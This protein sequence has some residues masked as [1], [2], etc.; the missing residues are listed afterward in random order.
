MDCT[1]DSTTTTLLTIRKP[2]PTKALA[3][4]S[5]GTSSRAILRRKEIASGGG[6]SKLPVWRKKA[7][8]RLTHAQS[9]QEYLQRPWQCQ[10]PLRQ[11]SPHASAGAE[12]CGLRREDA[13][14]TPF[15]LGF[16]GGERGQERTLSRR[17]DGPRGR[18]RPADPGEDCE[19]DVRFEA[20]CG[21]AARLERRVSWTSARHS[22]GGDRSCVCRVTSALAQRVGKICRAIRCFLVCPGSRLRRT[23][24]SGSTLILVNVLAEDLD[25][26]AS[27]LGFFEAA[28]VE[29]RRA[30]ESGESY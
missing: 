21:S 8:S 24:T 7:C 15:H 3:Q 16:Q 30:R 18:D 20:A 12:G 25:D 13:L 17:R 4:S 10:R 23:G 27:G 29:C 6:T 28:A 26:S 5:A 19:P 1:P 11:A 22:E 9:N 14:A 2:M